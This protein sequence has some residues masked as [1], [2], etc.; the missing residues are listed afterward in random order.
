M[1]ATPAITRDT[2]SS[3]LLP[4]DT[5][6]TRSS[7]LIRILSVIPGT[8]RLARP[9]ATLLSSLDYRSTIRVTSEARMP[10]PPA[11]SLILPPMRDTLNLPLQPLLPLE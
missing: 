10:L 9:T 3:S 11:N 1:A 6:N 5:L 2:S 4:L 7:S 8:K